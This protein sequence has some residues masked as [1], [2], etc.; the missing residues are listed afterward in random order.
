MLHRRARAK[1][2]GTVPTDSLTSGNLDRKSFRTDPTSVG[3]PVLIYQAW[4]SENP[5]L[6]AIEDPQK[7]YCPEATFQCL[8]TTEKARKPK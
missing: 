7:Y 1:P 6:E 3:E 5:R 8:R 4:G 2:V